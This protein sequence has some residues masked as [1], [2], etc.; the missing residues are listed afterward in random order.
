MQNLIDDPAF[1][2]AADTMRDKLIAWC[3]ANDDPLLPV[4]RNFYSDRSACTIENAQP[5]RKQ[6]HQ[7]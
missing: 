7:L 3:A 2:Q 5:Y 1:Q 4:L 6:T